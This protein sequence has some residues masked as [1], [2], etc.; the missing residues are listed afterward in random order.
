MVFQWIGNFPQVVEKRGGDFDDL[1]VFSGGF[2][3]V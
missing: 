1:A 3:V 2:S